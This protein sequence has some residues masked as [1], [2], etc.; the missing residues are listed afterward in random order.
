MAGM[1]QEVGE[2]RENNKE[3]DSTLYFKFGTVECLQ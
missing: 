2:T 3:H 1:L